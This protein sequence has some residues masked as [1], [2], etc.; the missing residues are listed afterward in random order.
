MS[1]STLVDNDDYD[2]DDDDDDDDV[3]FI[4]SIAAADK[5]ST[6]KRKLDTDEEMII[7]SS[8]HAKS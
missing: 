1:L 4:G 3:V 7:P 2:A 6:N 8:K 5:D